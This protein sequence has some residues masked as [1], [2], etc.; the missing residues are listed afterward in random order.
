VRLADGYE[1]FLLD[2]D[3]VLYR[4]G[5]AIPGAPEAVASLRRAGRRTV[6]VTNNSARTPR[7]VA[8]R[9]GAM[10]FRADPGDV[11]TSAQATARLLAR[12]AADGVAPTAFVL[13]EEGIRA[14]LAEDGI[15]VL[16]G[17]PDE[18]GFVV[19][20]WDRAMTYDRLRVAS[21]LVRRG[22]RLVATN[23][24]ATYPAPGGDLWPGAGALVAAVQTAAGRPATVVGKPRPGLFRTALEVAGA[25]R[26]LVV[27]DRLETDVAGAAA[28]G[29]DAV[30]VRTGVAALAD[31]LDHAAQPVA[32]LPDV[33]GLL[34]ERPAV[35]VR[36]AASRDLDAVRRL[37]DGAGLDGSEVDGVEGTVVAGDGAPVATAS[38]DVRGT[39][40]YVRSVAV[41]EEARGFSIG[42]LVVAAAVRRAADAGVTT[43]HLLTESAAGFF[44]ALGFR[45]VPREGLPPWVAERSQS[46][47]ASA[48][49]MRRGL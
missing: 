2:L 40:G 22:A 35:R 6:F 21:V 30:L 16:D 34:E 28:A 10:G 4:G 27:G 12:E 18:V 38:V 49:A 37:V 39:E 48:T 47:S 24:D 1:A 11:V 31:L 9:L 46:C 20:G 45:A 43:L 44:E 5:G 25:T 8:E 23:A 26:A 19:V 13:G 3:G 41:A 17:E 36:P 15:E 7:Q 42:A 32:V 33:S 14:A 29:L